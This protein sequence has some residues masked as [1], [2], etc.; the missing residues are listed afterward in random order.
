MTHLWEVAH[1]FYCEEGCY[2]ASG[3][4]LEW[5]HTNCS[6][7]NDFME[8]WGMADLDM[9]LVFRWDWYKSDPDDYEYE[10]KE[11]P[12]F[13]LPGDTLRIY[14]YL[15]RKAYGSSVFV[16]VTE[17]DEPAVR[18]WLKIRAEHMRN[19]WEPLLDS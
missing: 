18:E 8:G 5:V 12:D 15:Q 19:L 10:M 1:S 7:W 11:D 13:K 14:F 9:N 3:S 4:Y 2:F 17:D 16:D 6:S